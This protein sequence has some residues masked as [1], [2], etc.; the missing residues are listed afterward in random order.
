[1]SR[2]RD[3]ANNWA[4]DITGVTAG[5]GITGGGTSGTV[6]VTNDMATTIDAKGDLVVGSGADAFARLAVG[7]NDTV[8]TADSSTATGLKWAAA[9]GGPTLSQVASGSLSGGTVSITGLTQ[10]NLQLIL[11]GV[12]SNA[13]SY[14][15]RLNGN[16]GSNYYFNSISWQ[17]SYTAGTSNFF[18]GSPTT[19][20]VLTGYPSII[21][22]NTSN[23]FIVNLTACK[24]AGFTYFE[25]QNNYQFDTGGAG[26]TG[27]TINRGYFGVAAQ[28]TSIDVIANGG[29]F[30]AGS[31]RVIG[32]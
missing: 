29:T 7:S 19:S 8:L 16:S 13:T 1:M 14:T 27:T 10:D 24:A 28:I 20:L 31:Y 32:G 17:P 21:S 6:T 30:S 22:A 3:N 9:G 18:M 26:Q 2:A 11:F 15:V 12:S 23:T 4:A 25:S 5:T